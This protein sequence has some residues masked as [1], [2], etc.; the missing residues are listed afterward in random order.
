MKRVI[1][2]Y[3]VKKNRVAEHEALIQ[4]V[5]AELTKKEPA[6][7]RYGVFKEPDGVTFVHVATIEGKGNPLEKIAAFGA[8]TAKISERAEEQPKA[9]D[10]QEVG[11]YRF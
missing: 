3:R 8:F 6:G 9:L 1:V 10:L 7:L 5:F 2:R 11:N 4:D